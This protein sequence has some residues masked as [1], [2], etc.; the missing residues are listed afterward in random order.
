MQDTFSTAPRWKRVGA[1]LGVVWSFLF[2]FTI[3]GWFALGHYKKWKRGEIAT[4]NLLIG[5]G[6]AFAA[7]VIVVMLSSPSGS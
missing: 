4:P 5:W 1:I 7:L 6:Y 3:P 2:F